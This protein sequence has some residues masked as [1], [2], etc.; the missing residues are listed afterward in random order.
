MFVV[1]IDWFVAQ[2]LGLLSGLSG[3]RD[4]GGGRGR[5]ATK[6]SKTKRPLEGHLVHFSIF[7]G[8]TGP[9]NLIM[10]QL[11]VRD[12]LF[13]ALACLTLLKLYKHV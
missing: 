9:L 12:I 8:T 6:R 2:L 13:L 11:H 1:E 4:H 7:R 5:A 10:G 3:L